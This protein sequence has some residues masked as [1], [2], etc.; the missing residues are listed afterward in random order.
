MVSGQH[1]LRGRAKEPWAG[2]CWHVL[3]G[4]PRARHH[5]SGKAAMSPSRKGWACLRTSGPARPGLAIHPEKQF[6]SPT[7]R[8]LAEDKKPRRCVSQSQQIREDR[9]LPW[10]WSTSHRVALKASPRGGWGSKAG[11]LLEVTRVG[12]WLLCPDPL[13]LFSANKA[14][15]RGVP[16]GSRIQ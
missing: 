16:T 10:P 15:H 13:C 14:G 5:C 1:A 8:M 7:R 9:P 4:S 2:H 3:P 11:V 6:Y 12:A